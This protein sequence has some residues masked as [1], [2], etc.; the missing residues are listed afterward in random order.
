MCLAYLYIHVYNCFSYTGSNRII[1]PH[2]SMFFFSSFNDKHVVIH[3]QIV[4][5]S[6]RHLMRRPK[7]EKAK[8]FKHSKLYSI[9]VI[10]KYETWQHVAVLNLE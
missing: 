1:S 6:N 9:C 3:E 2:H 4:E 5:K 7:N 8:K 10:V